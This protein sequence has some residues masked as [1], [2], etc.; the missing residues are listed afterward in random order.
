LTIAKQFGPF[1]GESAK[2]DVRANFFNALNTLN[3]AGFTP[4]T[5]PTDIINTGQF[6]RSPNGLSGRVIEFQARFSF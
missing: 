1:F 3:L 6:G 2:L 4:A 5:E